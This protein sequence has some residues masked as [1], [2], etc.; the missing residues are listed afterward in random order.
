M[1]KLGADHPDTL[2]T[3][4]NLAAAYQDAGRLAGGDAALRAGPRR[5]RVAK[6]GADHPDT[7]TTLNNLGRGLYR[8]AG[9]AGPEAHP[10]CYEQVRD[11][12]QW[13]SWGR[14]TPTRWRR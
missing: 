3:L 8:A 12:A 5:C 13:P 4:N 6:L 14:T 11:A 2:A 9:Q 10:G 1:A 7:L